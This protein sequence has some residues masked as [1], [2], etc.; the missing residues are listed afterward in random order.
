MQREREV[1]DGLKCRLSSVY[2]RSPIEAPWGATEGNRASVDRRLEDL[3]DH[4]R[5]R[6]EARKMSTGCS[7]VQSQYAWMF[8]YIYMHIA[9]NSS[10]VL[11]YKME[12]TNICKIKYINHVFMHVNMHAQ[13]TYKLLVF[14][15][16]KLKF[17][18]VHY[19]I[20]TT[21]TFLY[22]YLIYAT[23]RIFDL[24][25]Y[26]YMYVNEKLILGIQG[27]QTCTYT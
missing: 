12:K 24:T 11:V 16:W 6:Q 23:Y 17:T 8:D 5:W 18:S 4:I 10:Y 19:S 14:A 26:T 13:C 21:S 15:C 7:V 20:Y 25:L 22:F 27:R 1:G 2:A 9:H 3:L